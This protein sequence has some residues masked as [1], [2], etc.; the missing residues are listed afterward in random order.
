MKPLNDAC[1]KAVNAARRARETANSFFQGVRRARIKGLGLDYMDFRDYAYGD[2]IKHVDWRLSARAVRPEGE[3]RLI[4]KEYEAERK[5]HAVL[6]TDLS[7][8]M[9]FGSKLWSAVY[10]SS[11]I[12]YTAAKLDDEL[13]LILMYNTRLKT[14]WRI[15]PNLVPNIVY[16]IIC[17][18]GV[19]GGSSLSLLAEYARR[20]R[21]R[22]PMI[23]ITDYD[24]TLGEVRD[25]A[26]SL[27]AM[28]VGAGVILI[29]DEA[30]LTPP[31]DDA[32]LSLS[33]F[34]EG[35]KVTGSLREIYN[36]ILLHVKNLRAAVKT[37]RLKFLEL[38]GEKEALEWKTRIL[39]M[40][41]QVR[42]VRGLLG[43]V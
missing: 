43:L 5:I 28:G 21:L 3:M 31:L 16:N 10:A 39:N 33:E 6:V 18:K 11:L 40:Y 38:I 26:Y 13:T 19:S 23:I 29:A 9:G 24:H 2:D 15:Q 1:K 7:A 22:N 41:L 42:S 14:F 34:E 30:E 12:A 32:F 27:R 36:E 37:S 35:E 25:L 8:S 4:V 17:D 20:M